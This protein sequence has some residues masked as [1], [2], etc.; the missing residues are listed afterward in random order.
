L[1]ATTSYD[2][3]GNP[4][5]PGGLTSY[6]P[7]GYAGGYTD[8]DGLIYLINRYYDPAEGQFISVDPDLSQT[9]EPYA[10]TGGDPL[11]EKDPDGTKARSLM[12]THSF[13][14]TT[15][16][17]S[18]SLSYCTP[19][20]AV[21]AAQNFP[22]RDTGG[23]ITW[24]VSWIS[25]K[26][27]VSLTSTSG[28]FDTCARYGRW[29]QKICRRGLIEPVF[30]FSLWAPG[31][32]GRK[33]KL[34]WDYV[35]QLNYNPY[36]LVDHDGTGKLILGPSPEHPRYSFFGGELYAYNSWSS[37]EQGGNSWYPVPGAGFGH[38]LS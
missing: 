19:I 26:N 10:Y 6:T 7:F 22:V 14:V 24:R 17:I 38:A 1:L 11:A 20:V 16:E 9:G 30:L 5:T 37:P 3:W 33:T 29:S 12:N 2:A 28:T 18:W 27:T 34:L 13:S 4:T 8:T 31:R 23:K 32:Y 25:Y 36:K 35:D 21:C 15:S